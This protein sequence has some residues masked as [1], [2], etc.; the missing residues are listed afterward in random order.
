MT[1]LQSK[2]K[3]KSLYPGFLTAVLAISAAL[4]FAQMNVVEIS[5]I[6]TDPAGE[7]VRGAAIAATNTATGLKFNAVDE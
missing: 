6:V 7:V 2:T 3:V 4:S 1:P 5:G